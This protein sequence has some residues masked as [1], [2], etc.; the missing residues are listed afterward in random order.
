MMSKRSK[1]ELTE[2]IQ[3]RYLKA[4]KTEKVKILDE[5][6]AATG[7]HRK[8]AIKLLKH[9]LKRKGYKKVGRKKIYQGEVVEI[10]ERIWET[11]GK[12]CSKRLHTFIP[13]MVSVLER[14]GELSCSPETK[15]LL[16]SMSRNGHYT[17]KILDTTLNVIE[18][19]SQTPCGSFVRYGL[20]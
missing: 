5:F 8:Y 15:T 20:T 18:T 16:L 14:E 9:G 7:Y 17:H 10:F 2:E 12:I 11:C 4:G 6:T 1:R 13:E 19:L 3:P